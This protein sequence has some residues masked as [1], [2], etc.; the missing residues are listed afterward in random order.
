MAKNEIYPRY[1][2]G[3]DAWD[4]D[5]FD[6]LLREAR[7]TKNKTLRDALITAHIPLVK[8][9]AKGFSVPGLD[10]GDV[11]G[12]G[13]IGLINC[14]DTMYDLDKE[15]R[16]FKGYAISCIKGEIRKAIADLGK[17]IR[18]P[19]YQKDRLSRIAFDLE[20]HQ[21]T[22]GKKPSVEELAKSTNIPEENVNELINYS[23]KYADLTTLDI[24]LADGDE[25]RGARAVDLNS[26]KE[27]DSVS[28]KDHLKR[29]L[30]KTT[31]LTYFE[32]TLLHR[33]YLSFSGFM[34]NEELGEIYKVSRQRVDQW[35]TRIRRKIRNANSHF[36]E[37]ESAKQG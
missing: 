27:F 37:E 13:E 23:L 6:E 20:D 18:L 22:K 2:R 24:V 11:I 8:D 29:V 1:V 3:K 5:E 32:K 34:S 33:K 7:L 19:V 21:K 36:I 28:T 16:N 9:V 4:N 30:D 10:R 14:V 35:L 25:F 15:G 31:S 17:T 12:F 26:E